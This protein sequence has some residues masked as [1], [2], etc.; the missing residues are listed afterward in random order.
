MAKKYVLPKIMIGIPTYDQKNYCLEYFMDNL[1]G[2]TYPKNLLEIYVADNSKTNKNALHIRD[3]YGVKTFWKNYDDYT[4]FQKMADSHNQLRSYFLESDC[5][6]LLHLESDI[7]P[8]KDVIEQLLWCR[9]PIACA[10]YQVFDGSHRQPCIRLQDKNNEHYREYQ[11]YREMQHFHHFWVDGKLKETFI[12]GIGCALMSRNLL[13]KVKFRYDTSL[14]ENNP[15]D[16]YFAVDVRDLGV[17]NYVHTGLLCFHWNR[18]EWGRHSELIK[19][20]K[21]E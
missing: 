19:Y 21:A 12:A 8:P 9:Q 15:P 4:L 6:F 10:F 7:F 18:E 2:F 20:S 5:E 1:N 17:Q 16:T 13:N 11:F 3:K 14:I